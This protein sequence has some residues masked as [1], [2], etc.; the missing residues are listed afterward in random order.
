MGRY[1]LP[2]GTTKRKKKKQFKKKE[3]NK[4]NFQEIKLFGSL[5]TKVLKNNIHHTCRKGSDGQAAGADRTQSKAVA[6]RLCGPTFTC[7]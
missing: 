2:P 7:K 5:T 3:K 1:D 4:Q 6:G